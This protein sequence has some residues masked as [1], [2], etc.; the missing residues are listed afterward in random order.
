MVAIRNG[1]DLGGRGN[2]NEVMVEERMIGMT[3]GSCDWGSE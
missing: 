3:G 2:G 1:T